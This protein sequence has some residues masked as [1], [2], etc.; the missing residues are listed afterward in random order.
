VRHFGGIG[1]MIDRPGVSVQVTAADQWADL[2]HIDGE[3][4]HFAR[5]FVG[6]FPEHQERAFQVA[7]RCAPTRH[8]GLGS[9]T[10]LA[11]AVAKA[12]AIELGLPQHD[13]AYLAPRVGRGKRSGIGVHGFDR[14][15]FL[16][17]GGKLPEQELSPLLGRYDFPQDWQVLLVHAPGTHDWHGAREKAAFTQYSQLE[18]SNLPEVL[19]R[20]LVMSILPALVSRDLGQF[21]AALEEFNSRVGDAFAAEQGGRYASPGIAAVIAKLQALG[22]PGCGQSSWGPTVFAIIH[23]SDR[24]KYAELIGYPHTFAQASLGHRVVTS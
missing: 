23:E 15:G 7:V 8:A 14:G 17:E 5:T 24:E 2:D 11:L 12:I 6:S 20:L 16:V 18:Q 4:I 22:A 13:A 1:L 21:G 3:A 10:Q 19:S 9:G